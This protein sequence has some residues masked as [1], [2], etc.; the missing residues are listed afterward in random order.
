MNLASAQRAVNDLKDSGF[1]LWFYLAKNQDNY[2]F[3][4]SQ[5]ACAEWGIK[6]DSYYRAV[7]EL[8]DKGYLIAGEGEGTWQF[9]DS[10]KERAAI[11]VP[12]KET[13]E[14]SVPPSKSWDF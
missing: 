6:K 5:K 4:L 7:S 14:I 8:K 3:A 13:T 2:E 1:K 10:P 9:F 11:S 12:P